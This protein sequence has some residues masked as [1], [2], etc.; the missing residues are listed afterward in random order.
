MRMV[1]E[2][3]LLLL[4]L[5]V[6]L[7]TVWV[8][9]GTSSV[10]RRTRGGVRIIRGGLVGILEKGKNRG[11]TISVCGILAG[12]VGLALGTLYFPIIEGV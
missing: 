3:L 12:A 10:R 5:V 6:V 4:L 7:V 1:M 8:I 9:T 11:Q 2:M